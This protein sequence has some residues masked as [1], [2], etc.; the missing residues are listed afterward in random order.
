MITD[1]SEMILEPKDSITDA[2]VS[3]SFVLPRLYLPAL[4]VFSFVLVTSWRRQAL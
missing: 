2:Q 3:C 4:V 1:N